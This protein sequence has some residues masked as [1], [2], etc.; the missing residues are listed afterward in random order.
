LHG[1]AAGEKAVKTRAGNPVE[2]VLEKV[3]GGGRT[4]ENRGGITMSVLRFLTMTFSG[5]SADPPDLN[6]DDDSGSSHRR[7]RRHRG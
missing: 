1:A 4:D 5:R 6:P 7:R 2:M 3:A